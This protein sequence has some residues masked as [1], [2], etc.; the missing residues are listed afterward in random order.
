MELKDFEFD[1]PEDLIAQRPLGER[2]ASRLMVLDRA[3]GEVTH[4]GFRAVVERL[5]A[6]DLV[7][8]N[9]TRV[10]PARLL[11]TKPTG[12]HVEVLLVERLPS[13][14]GE[15][16]RALVKNSKGMKTGASINLGG[17]ER[18]VIVSSEADGFWKVSFNKGFSGRLDGI[19]LM[20]LP[21]YIRREP[22]KADELR[23][24]TVFAGASGAVA[25][26]TAGLHFTE[27]ILDELKDKG[28]ELRRITLHTGPGTFMPVR[29]ESIEEHR[30]LPERYTIAP[31]VAEA[32]RRAKSENRRVV[33]VGTTSTRALEAAF[34]SGLEDPVL[35]GATD[36]FIYP[37][38][39]FT[40]VD[41]LLTNF[42]LPGSTL[43]ML[44]CAFAGREKV[45]AAYKEAVRMRYRFFSYG[46]A[47]LII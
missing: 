44:V 30:M 19:G 41:A 29:V 13:D 47:M 17:G 3:T 28:V 4:A 23:Y 18:A 31:E 36:L 26:P 5:R 37:G 15:L 22:E 33:A 34:R 32:V 2:D 6:G 24:Q 46:D 8:V 16:W 10:F 38:F 39:R 20:P 1:L 35:S 11:G 21:P 7:I 27:S 12:G 9:D 25:A 42:H 40:V 45:L 14:S 43:I